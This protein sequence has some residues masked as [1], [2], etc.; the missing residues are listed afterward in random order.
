MTNAPFILMKTSLKY[1]VRMKQDLS[2]IQSRL[3]QQMGFKLQYQGFLVLHGA[4]QALGHLIP[5]PKN[6]FLAKKE[7]DKWE[8]SNPGKTWE[9]VHSGAQGLACFKYP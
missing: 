3:I 6:Q 8:T 9:T 4:F 5:C 2:C 1:I 7:L